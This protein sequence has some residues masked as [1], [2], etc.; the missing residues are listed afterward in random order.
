M[1]PIRSM[2][3]FGL[4]VLFYSHYALPEEN[5]RLSWRFSAGTSYFASNIVRPLEEAYIEPAIN[6]SH[7]SLNGP[8]PAMRLEASYDI[9]RNMFVNLGVEYIFPRTFKQRIDLPNEF[10]ED[11]LQNDKLSMI[12]VSLGLGYSIL[13][14]ARLNVSVIAG[15]DLNI[16]LDS[17]GRRISGR[18][19]TGASAFGNLHQTNFGFRAGT[20]IAFDNFFLDI[21][22][23]LFEITLQ[24]DVFMQRTFLLPDQTTYRVVNENFKAGDFWGLD[25]NPMTVISIGVGFKI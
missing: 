16:I 7:K 9:T 11:V 19:Q 22:A 25:N 4:S 2:V 15:A 18:L 23:R 1:R 5:N 17:F 24:G 3:F 6:N 20:R 10:D 21:S 13:S 14:T 8:S 12:P